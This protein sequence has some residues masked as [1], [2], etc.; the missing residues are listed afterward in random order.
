MAKKK[1]KP[2]PESPSS[3]SSSSGAPPSSPQPSSDPSSEA[4]RIERSYELG[5][6]SAVRALAATATTP[7]GKAAAERLLPRV[8]VERQQLYVG[9]FGVA[10]VVTA[11]FLA[12]TMG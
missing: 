5:N 8:K 10:V 4:A 9:L 2:E 1:K 7:D 11:C 12:L 6:F 3:S